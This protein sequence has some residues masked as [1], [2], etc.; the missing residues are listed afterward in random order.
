MLR[1]TNTQYRLLQA[2]RF[3]VTENDDE[4]SYA[5]CAELTEGQHWEQKT[6]ECAQLGG[7]SSFYPHYFVRIHKR[8]NHFDWYAA[9]K[10]ANLN[11]K[12]AEFMGV[13]TILNQDTLTAISDI[14]WKM[15]RRPLPDRRD[16]DVQRMPTFQLKH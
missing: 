5:S 13:F 10:L 9:P 3:E 15:E 4:G 6:Y 7:F 1:F 14:V 2:N 8:Q 12:R 16:F 11:A